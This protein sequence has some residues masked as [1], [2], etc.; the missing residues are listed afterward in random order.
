M[1]EPPCLAVHQP[2]RL[3]AEALFT[4]KGE[5]RRWLGIGDLAHAIIPLINSLA[6]LPHTASRLAKAFLLH[7]LK[8]SRRWAQR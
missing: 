8:R 7:P 4:L 5:A 1:G 6:K 2:K 3:E